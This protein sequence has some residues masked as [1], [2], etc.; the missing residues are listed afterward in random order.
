MLLPPRPLCPL[1]LSSD[2]EWLELGGRGKVKTFTV[3]HVAPQEFRDH[4]PYTVAIVELEEGVKIT[5]QVK[6]I[7]PEEVEIGMEV[8]IDFESNKSGEWPSWAR[9]YFRPV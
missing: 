4:T 5:G 8:E 3:I 9:Y 7:R 2:L 1:C 6:G